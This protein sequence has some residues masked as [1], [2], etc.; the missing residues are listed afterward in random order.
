M[1]DYTRQLALACQDRGDAC[2]IV[3]LNEVVDEPPDPAEEAGVLYWRLGS[4]QSWGKRAAAVKKIVGE[5]RPD[6]VSLQFVPYGY[7]PRGLCRDLLKVLQAVGR[8]PQKHV[9]FHELFLGL[10]REESLKNRIVGDLQRRIIRRLL[11]EWKPDC[12]HTHAAPYVAWLQ[13]H[14]PNVRA[15]PLVG[16]IPLVS[17][18]GSVSPDFDH[19]VHQRQHSDKQFWMGGYFGTFY[20]GGADD[21]FVALLRRFAKATDRQMLCFLAGRQDSIARERWKAL[22]ERSDDTLRWIYLGELDAAAVSRYLQQLDFG[23]A[24]TP[25]ALSGKSGGIAAMREHGLP[26]L[27]PRNDWT[28]R[29]PVKEFL[30][31]GLVPAWQ[32][33]AGMQVLRQ[34]KPS[35]SY[36]AQELHT[37]QFLKDIDATPR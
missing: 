17:G 16:N 6:W 30:Q 12:V 35:T 26:V 15:L 33:D 7:H 2:G 24:A 20:P 21:G 31:N 22:E 1:G 3:S 5:F 29:F 10:H 32:G 11:Q 19:W 28:P 9:F 14:H 23:I 25:W 8:H 4:E 13:K 18:K 34:A 27:V 37:N 36:D